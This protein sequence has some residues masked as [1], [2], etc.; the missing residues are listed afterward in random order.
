MPQF[1]VVVI[2]DHALI[3]ESLV[4]LLKM[5]KQFEIVGESGDSETAIEIVGRN[6]PDIVFL[7]INIKPRDGF[8]IIKEIMAVSPGSKVIA[9]S[10]YTLPAYAKKM[11][12]L[13]ARAYVT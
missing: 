3:R 12:A 1:A 8:E 4:H 9:L 11:I 10:M 13:G 7:D 2:D 5:L 6:L